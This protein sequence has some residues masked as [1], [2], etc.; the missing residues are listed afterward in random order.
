[1]IQVQHLN[2]A[3]KSRNAKVVFVMLPKR[4]FIERFQRSP[5]LQDISFTIQE[6]EMVGYIGPNGAGKST[7]IKIMCGVLTPDDG[8]CL[9]NGRVP[10]KE[11][12]DHVRRHWRCLWS[13]QSALVGCP[14]HRQF[15]ADS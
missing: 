10:W 1:M 13:T 2:K 12:I 14:S 3:S 8:T 9:I 5:L 11:R 4:S 15:R 7:T 6:G